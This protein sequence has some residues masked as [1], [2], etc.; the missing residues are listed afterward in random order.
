M[1]EWNSFL[2]LCFLLAVRKGT[3]IFI[4]LNPI[5]TVE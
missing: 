5:L 1:R 4:I 3:T 2:D